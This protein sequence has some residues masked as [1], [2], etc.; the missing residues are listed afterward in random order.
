MPDAPSI[1]LV[2]DYSPEVIAHRAIPVALELANRDL[3]AKATWSWVQTRDI[4]NAARDLA[5][6]AA[7]WVVPASPYEN[8]AG[9]LGA[10]RWARETKRPLLGTCGGFQHMLIEF[11]RDVA[12]LTGADHAESNPEG[13]TLVVTRLSCSLVEK[14]SDVHFTPG[15]RLQQIYG[16]STADERYRCNYGLNP[17][18][19]AALEKAGMLFTAHDDNG[20]IRGA[21]LPVA[22][23]PFFVGTLFQPERAALR[24]ETPPLARAFVGA[25]T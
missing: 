14:S 2:G 10:I 13:S 4:N 19:A 15:S 23:H 20:E 9:A 1:A 5:N 11:A 21:E 18:H 3:G 17:A 6:F 8:M 25:V 16:G 12:G 7:V 22:M 24:G